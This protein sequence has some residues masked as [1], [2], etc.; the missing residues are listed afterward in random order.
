MTSAY[1]A[2][3]CA[4]ESQLTPA[5][6]AGVEQPQRIT[7]RFHTAEQRDRLQRLQRS[8][9]PTTGPVMPAVRQLRS[10]SASSGHRQR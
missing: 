10:G 6:G 7:L 9:H 5:A 8:H 3:A 1:R 2:L 4:V